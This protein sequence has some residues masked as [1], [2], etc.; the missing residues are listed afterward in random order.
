M[1][2]RHSQIFFLLSFLFGCAYSQDG[3]QYKK[4]N[5]GLFGKQTRINYFSGDRY[6]GFVFYVKIPCSR[7]YVIHGFYIYPD[8]RCNGYG[9][10]LFKH[11]CERVRT[12]HYASR[13]ESAKSL[14][15]LI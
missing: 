10:K 15:D 14:K 9:E 1:I 11:A 6:I 2:F 13:Q 12:L 4:V 8:Y 7:F 3:F 5:S